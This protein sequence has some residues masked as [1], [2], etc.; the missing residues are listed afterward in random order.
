MSHRSLTPVLCFFLLSGLGCATFA[1]EFT[2][3]VTDV[4]DGDSLIFVHNGD[5]ERI[6]LYAVDCPE[7]SQRF[8]PEAKEATAEW[9]RD[10]NVTVKAWGI[11]FYTGRMTGIVVLPDGRRLNHQLVKAGLAW[12]DRDYPDERELAEFEAQ[13]RAAKRGLWADPHPTP[14]WE[15]RELPKTPSASAD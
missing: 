15:F 13:A 2:G 14:P 12:W 5:R 4:T 3:Q 6:R 11:D 1:V 9:A 7:L 10:Q 8:G